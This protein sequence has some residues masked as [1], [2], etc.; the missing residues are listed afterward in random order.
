MWGE[1]NEM[2]DMTQARDVRHSRSYH[3]VIFDLFSEFP[4]TLC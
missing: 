3:S 2:T 1:N 4:S